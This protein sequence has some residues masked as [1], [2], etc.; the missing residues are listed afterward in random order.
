MYSGDTPQL[1]EPSQPPRSAWVKT[2]LRKINP[3]TFSPFTFSVLSEMCF[4]HD[5]ERDF[6]VISFPRDQTPHLTWPD[7]TWLFFLLLFGKSCRADSSTI[8][9]AKK[10]TKQF[11][12]LTDSAVDTHSRS[13]IIITQLTEVHRFY[14][15][16]LPSNFLQ[17]TLSAWD[18]VRGLTSDFILHPDKHLLLLCSRLCSSLS[19]SVKPCQVVGFTGLWM[20]L[21][22][23]L[24]GASWHGPVVPLVPVHLHA[25][26][27]GRVSYHNHPTLAS[28]C[29]YRTK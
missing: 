4:W 10:P 9:T 19:D 18:Q 21:C 23:A 15:L 14:W 8:C 27:T 29:N 24:A 20:S 6:N 25:R 22:Y 26:A 16:P 11:T 5:K 13:L 3:E 2:R 12:H 1:N 7:V 17:V 28:P